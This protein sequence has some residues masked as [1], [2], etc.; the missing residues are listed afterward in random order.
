[1]PGYFPSMKVLITGATGFLGSHLTRRMIAEGHDVRILCRPTSSYARLAG[2]NVEKVVGDITDASSLQAAVKNRDYV[3]HAAANVNYWRG[4]EHWQTRVNVEGTRN[5]ARAAREAGV[6]RLLHVSSV[7]AIGISADPLHPANENFSFNLKGPRWTYHLSKHWAEQQIMAEVASG[8]DAVIVNPAV[9]CGPASD[10]YHIAEP[11]KKTLKDSI[12]PYAPGGLCL[13]H[14]EDVAG[15]IALALE[16]GRPGE[17]YILGGS[18]VS[19][20]EMSDEVC[21]QFS[22]RRL[23]VRVPGVL[24]GLKASATNTFRRI[25]GEPPL[26]A[27]TRRFCYQFYDSSRARAELA[28]EARDF[29]SLL[30][31]FV[32]LRKG[33]GAG[34]HDSATG[35]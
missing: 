33:G 24:A 26:P 32:S 30:E 1:M 21:K 12:I 25:Q 16:K 6:K 11:V 3:I 18:N 27:Y 35:T 28:W 5:V 13:V 7:A 15:G 29:R 17:R 10:D 22:V 23:H 4:E 8:L 19:F 2:L 31:E 9:I 20:R 14:I 34:R